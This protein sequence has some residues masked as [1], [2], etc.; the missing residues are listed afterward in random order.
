M[1]NIIKT[2]SY[3]VVISMLL[4]SSAHAELKLQAKTLT[5]KP[6]GAIAAQAVAKPATCASGF[7]AV[8]K[9][10]VQ[11][12][13]KKWYEYTC[14][15]EEVINRVCNTDT[16]VIDVKDKFISLPSD[17]QSKKSKLQMSYK[18]FNYVPVE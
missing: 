7:V 13:G 17:G 5:P 4:V 15:H 11:H 3:T 14:A 16:Q 8:G 18:C 2:F 10:L 6:I 1:K 12:E 9:K